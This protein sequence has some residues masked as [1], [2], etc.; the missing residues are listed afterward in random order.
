M[1]QLPGVS[2]VMP[3]LNEADYLE[4]A[5]SSILGQDYSGEKELVLALGPSTD[6]TNNVARRLAD[7]DARIVLVHNPLGRT[8][9]GLNLAI[10]ASTL[11]IVIRVDAH[12]ELPSHYTQRGIETLFR[13]NA[14]DVGGLMDAKGRT[15]VQRGIAAAYHSKFGFGGPAYHS[16]AP[17]GSAESAYLGIFRREVFEEVGYYNE[18][19]WR[20]Q[21]WELCLRIRQ[22]GHTVWFDPEL[23]VG[24]YPRDSFKSLISQSMASG[25]W[26][27][28]IARRFPEGKSLRHDVP[29]LLLL[30]VATGLAATVIEPLVREA[31]PT[32]VSVVLNLAKAVPAVYAAI[33]LA[34]GLT[35]NAKGLKD[36]LLAACAFPAIH[37]PWAFGYIKGRFCG[38][39]GTVDKGRVR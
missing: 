10:R 11:P 9:I 3:V 25:T 32:G 34:A 12:S 27:A 4:E 2:Y 21:D 35:S 26:R 31:A 13:V 17:E 28:E 8:P 36:K 22:A 20:A 39:A 30:G 1:T 19:L 15:P 24:Y 14:H 5:V 18:E 37:L 16:G 23:K 6:T 33:A 29:P 38:A 7:A